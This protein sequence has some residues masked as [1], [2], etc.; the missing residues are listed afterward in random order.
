MGYYWQPA[1]HFTL[2]GGI[3]NTSVLL[4]PSTDHSGTSVETVR[5][6]E[7]TS[8][9]TDDTSVAISLNRKLILN[10]E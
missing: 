4:S 1:T 9:H 2:W 5:I 8:S 3:V 7:L 10:G 6:H